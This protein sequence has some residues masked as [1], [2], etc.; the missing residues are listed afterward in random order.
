MAIDLRGD[1]E[2]PFTRG[3]L[4]QKMA[5]YLDRVYSRRAA[6][7]PDAA[8]RAEGARPVRA[9]LLGRGAGA[10]R[11]AVRRDRALGRRAAGDPAVQLLRD[12]GQAPGEQPRPAVLPPPR[13]VEARPDD[14]RLGRVARLRIHD[15]PGPPRRR[16]DGGPRVPVPRQLGLEHGP[17]Q[18]PPL[19]P[20]DRGAAGGARRSSR[21]TPTGARPPRD[22]TGTSSPAPAPTPRSPW[23]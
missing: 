22:P 4:C 16:P 5:R 11:R 18:Q 15:R 12:D 19:E 2:H 8:G 13:R 17:H 23:A 10:D 6:D 9:D 20:D 3:F 7:V 21:S 14:L 1:R